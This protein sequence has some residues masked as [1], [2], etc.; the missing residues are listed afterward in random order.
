M[1]RKTKGRKGKQATEKPAGDSGQPDTQAGPS[2]QDA[3]P[4]QPGHPVSDRERSPERQ[5]SPGPSHGAGGLVNPRI[6]ALLR[7]AG[8]HQSDLIPPRSKDTVDPEAT[9]L[10]TPRPELF[11]AASNSAEETLRMAR[12]RI[13]GI[14]S[15]GEG[16]RKAAIEMANAMEE[17]C[18]G[19]AVL[20]FSAWYGAS[21]VLDV[22]DG[23]VATR[24]NP[25]LPEASHVDKLEAVLSN[26]DR[27]TDFK[28][29]IMIQVRK[30][31]LSDEFIESIR[32]KDLYDMHSKPPPLRLQTITAEEEKVH[33]ELFWRSTEEFDENGTSRRRWLTNDELKQRQ[34]RAMYFFKTREFVILIN[35]NHR[36]AA[37]L[38]IGRAIHEDLILLLREA[39]RGVE[40]LLSYRQRWT[41]LERRMQH[42]TYRALIF[43]DD[44]P[45]ELLLEIAKNFEQDPQKGEEKAELIFMTA[46]RYIAAISR[47][48]IDHPDL[49]RSA[50]LDIARLELIKKSGKDDSQDPQIGRR[51]DP[52]NVDD[53]EDIPVSQ[54]LLSQ[55]PGPGIQ[56]KDKSKL[57]GL[58]NGATVFQRICIL[59][60]NLELV[61]WTRSAYIVWNLHMADDYG[62]TML[63][64]YGGLFTARLWL[65]IET[66]LCIA[67]ATE[68][69]SST[70]ESIRQFVH[71]HRPTP[72]GY[73]DAEKSWKLAYSRSSTQPVLMSLWR[74]DLASR[75]GRLWEK[76]LQSSTKKGSK[77]DRLD[78][79]ENKNIS[80]QR[81][82]FWQFGQSLDISTASKAERQFGLLCQ[83]YALLP[84]SERPSLDH[85]DRAGSPHRDQR[86]NPPPAL[87]Y[88]GAGLP[89]KSRLSSFNRQARSIRTDEAIHIMTFLLQRDAFM[90]LFWTGIDKHQRL[91]TKWYK[92][93]SATYHAVLVAFKAIG[94]GSIRSR[95]SLIIDMLED[96][97]LASSMEFIERE[98]ETR[99]LS[100]NWIMQQ[101]TVLASQGGK[102]TRFEDA[103]AKQA[104]LMLENPRQSLNI[105]LKSLQRY[106]FS[107]ERLNPIRDEHP[108]LSV[109]SSQFWENAQ[110]KRWAQGIPEGNKLDK[111]GHRAFGWGLALD[112]YEEAIVQLVVR[113]PQVRPLLGFV[114]GVCRLEGRR[115]W[116]TGL[117]DTA[118]IDESPPSPPPD[119]SQENPRSSEPPP[120]PVPSRVLRER[121]E[122]SI[123]PT[124]TQSSVAAKKKA[125]KKKA[126]SKSTR[127]SEGTR[128]FTSGVHEKEQTEK[129]QGSGESPG[130]TDQAMGAASGNEMD[131]ESVIVPTSADVRKA[132]VVDIGSAEIPSTGR[133]MAEMLQPILPPEVL[134]QPVLSIILLHTLDGVYLQL[135]E[136]LRSEERD[137]AALKLLKSPE[138]HKLNG[139]L[140][141]CT[142]ENRFRLQN[143]LIEAAASA[144]DSEFSQEL[145]SLHLADQLYRLCLTFVQRVA[146]EFHSI[147]I[148]LNESMVEAGFM[149]GTDSLLKKDILVLKPTAND[150]MEVWLNLKHTFP[151]AYQDYVDQDLKA[152]CVQVGVADMSP[153]DYEN[154][155]IA[156]ALLHP[157]GG[158]GS[159]L[160]AI[161]YRSL[162]A[163]E[164]LPARN[165]AGVPKYLSMAS[166][167]V[168]L[169]TPRHFT[170]DLS[171]NLQRVASGTRLIDESSS[172]ALAEY[173]DVTLTAQ[174]SKSPWS[175][176]VF[177]C[178]GEF[179]PES[180]DYKAT[181]IWIGE[182]DSIG[183]TLRSIRTARSAVMTNTFD[184]TAGEYI[185]K[186]LQERKRQGH[187][188]SSTKELLDASV[189]AEQGQ[190]DSIPFDPPTGAPTSQLESLC[191]NTAM[192]RPPPVDASTSA[193]I[194][195][196]TTSKRER[197][198]IGTAHSS[199]S[200]PEKKRKRKAVKNRDTAEDE[201]SDDGMDI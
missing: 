186:Y 99:G 2:T 25:R 185:N 119:H 1:P 167:L 135:R 155:S 5:S 24:I 74:P 112:H 59:S 65:E 51:D 122:H 41:D 153:A 170:S 73:E 98:L 71:N 156:S 133:P 46:E 21:L 162:L 129:G 190:S 168:P 142:I 166:D 16:E 180:S 31:Q 131:T 121:T 96:P 97:A 165:N 141:G 93:N 87:F 4:S 37:M 123:A 105:A 63:K 84:L 177:V 28:T 152:S 191:L 79:W 22:V 201:S 163:H 70:V 132:R 72:G 45:M 172:C 148:K 18:W 83:L 42:C 77:N 139:A 157:L 169:P 54:P 174:Y 82:V 58:T 49:P 86:P 193:N 27:K 102:L 181:D 154:L 111:L 145:L 109:V 183:E 200:G 35:G 146:Q 149:A 125:P 57:A 195:R 134:A 187:V 94:L 60:P 55:N 30:G 85:A 113:Y 40:D 179:D 66:L 69:S 91:R 52:I 36:I 197:T 17:H 43:K 103:L 108:V 68:L 189:P 104:N 117:Y 47:L 130:R 48:H 143:E 88:P 15:S 199:S 81:H 101:S 164:A 67:S 192:S 136:S 106:L 110:L 61:I 3:P 176:G 26:P 160:Q 159:T 115:P 53:G 23:A 118:T 178:G 128:D 6:E 120:E 150:E 95:L 56:V 137:Q 80:L 147:G 90:W 64:P 12:Q 75:F 34:E 140:V 182:G 198:S 100:L 127:S 171:A 161:Q 78:M 92:T 44:T 19:V 116:F 14:L 144:I 38:R 13:D 29:P 124:P 158:S 194:P 89:C 184:S 33:Y 126:V 175:T 10:L 8:E 62:T 11:E 9:D 138:N 50:L 107:E 20:N 188:L 114:E 32:T 196:K 39:E 151:L 173:T 76:S 7:H